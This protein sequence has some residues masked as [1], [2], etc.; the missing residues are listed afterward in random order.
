MLMAIADAAEIAEWL[1]AI[2]VNAHY[3]TR[4]SSQN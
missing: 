1:G 3:K 2:S 4:G